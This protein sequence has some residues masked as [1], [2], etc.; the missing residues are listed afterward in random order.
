MPLVRMADQFTPPVNNNPELVMNTVASMQEILGPG[1]VIQVD[2][3]TVG[4]DFG[5]YGRTEE[6]I[7][8]ALFWLGGVDHE[9]YE[10]HLTRG[11][12]LPPLHNPSFAPD[13]GPAFRGGVAAMSRAVIDLFGNEQVVDQ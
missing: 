7:P 9:L 3:A 6:N 1:K 5:Q 2:P 4:E 13:F 10:S 8:V 12:F 11:T